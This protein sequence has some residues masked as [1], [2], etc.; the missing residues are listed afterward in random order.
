MLLYFV[1][2]LNCTGKA[3]EVIIP[4]HDFYCAVIRVL[5]PQLQLLRALKSRCSHFKHKQPAGFSFALHS[6]PGPHCWA[7][8]VGF[9]M[10]TWPEEQQSQLFQKTYSNPRRSLLELFSYLV[11]FCWVNITLILPVPPAEKVS[12][13]GYTQTFHICSFKFHQL[14]KPSRFFLFYWSSRGDICQTE[15]GLMGSWGLRGDFLM[16]F[17][18]SVQHISLQQETTSETKI[19]ISLL[20][21]QHSD[22]NG[23]LKKLRGNVTLKKNVHHSILWVTTPPCNKAICCLWVKRTSN[24]LQALSAHCSPPTQCYWITMMFCCNC[25]QAMLWNAVYQQ[26]FF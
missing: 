10:D 9:S 3:M 1:I 6:K 20:S 24:D 7:C 16:D 2:H 5:W 23:T 25:F 17:V 4:F 21:C 12:C 15:E 22:S 8:L 11:S 26:K 13:P 19:A 14:A 18:Y